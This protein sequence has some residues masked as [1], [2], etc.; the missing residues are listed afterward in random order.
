VPS[1]FFR[2]KSKG[3]ERNDGGSMRALK[4]ARNLEKTS[5]LED[6]A[7]K[8]RALASKFSTQVINK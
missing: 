3:P 7:S 8:K 6:Y 2:L 1:D 5:S 4:F